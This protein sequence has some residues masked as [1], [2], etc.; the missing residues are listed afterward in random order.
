[1][2]FS[3][4]ARQG[5]ADGSITATVRRW[6]RAQ[7]R[8]GGAY[9]VL[10]LRL[11]VR[12]V[13]QVTV[14]DLTPA[15]ARACGEQNLIALRRR[16]GDG[17]ETAASMPVWRVTFTVTG[18]DDR[19]LLRERP[20]SG[21]ELDDVLR[22]LARLDRAAPGGPWTRTVLQLIADRPHVV[23]TELAAQLGRERQEFKRDVRKLKQ[24][25]LTSSLDVG[26]ELS[27]R[28]RSV[29]DGMLGS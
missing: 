11:V 6:S 8:A 13:E 28:G 16:L 15:D 22:S 29:L 26:Y 21:E 4:D 9:R 10:G 24:R 17:P 5:L 19:L 2:L 14:A 27:A 12:T 7:V 20:A 25:G 23:S 1:M 3:V 18:P